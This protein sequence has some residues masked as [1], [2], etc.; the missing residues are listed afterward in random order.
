MY[1]IRIKLTPNAKANAITGCIDDVWQIR[2]KAQPI[3]GRANNE[4]IKY[5]SNVLDIAKSNISLDKGQTSR[6]K[7]VLVEG[8]EE[9]VILERLAKAAD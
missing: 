2:I 4:L 8:L 5:L 9:S 3:E 7:T 1:R 6:I